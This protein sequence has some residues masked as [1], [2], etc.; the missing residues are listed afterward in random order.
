MEARGHNS[1]R[2]QISGLSNWPDWHKK[3]AMYIHLLF[4][5]DR[6]RTTKVRSRPDIEHEQ[7]PVT[8]KFKTKQAASATIVRTKMLASRVH[9][10]PLGEYGVVVGSGLQDPGLV[11]DLRPPLSRTREAAACRGHIL[12]RAVASVCQNGRASSG[13]GGLYS[14]R[15]L[16]GHIAPDKIKHH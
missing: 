4:F 2:N 12:R 3:E 1:K 11:V 7:C 16:G 15:Q 5:R 6:Q 9:P 8:S 14:R 13:S 10:R